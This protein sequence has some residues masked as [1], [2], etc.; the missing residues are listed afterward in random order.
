MRQ[1]GQEFVLAAVGKAQRLLRPLAHLHLVL[2]GRVRLLQRVRA[3]ADLGQHVVERGDE[4]AD[5]SAVVARHAQREVAPLHHLARD[6]RHGRE[7]P[8][9][10]SLQARRDEARDQQR[11]QHHGAQDGTIAEQAVDEAV[12]RAQVDRADHLAVFHDVAEH[13]DLATL[14]AVAGR[15]RVRGNR[16]VRGRRVGG[17]A[18]A[19]ARVDRGREDLRAHAQHGEVLARRLFVVEREGRRRH[20]RHDVGLGHQV[21]RPIAL[22]RAQ[23]EQQ[24]GDGS[25]Q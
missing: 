22:E 10:G 24:H 7:R 2:E 18:R 5:F 4:H 1:R 3:A 20:A 6:V 12:A 15:G 16:L 19:V 21:V 23:V 8:R 14:D 13:G 9:D 17:E 11:A 25:R